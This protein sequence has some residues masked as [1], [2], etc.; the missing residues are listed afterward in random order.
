VALLA[1]WVGG[2][3]QLATKFLNQ[4]ADRKIEYLNAVDPANDLAGVPPL[5]RWYSSLRLTATKTL[6]EA[7]SKLARTMA[8]SLPRKLSANS[9]RQKR[10]SRL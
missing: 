2:D 6:V 4:A 1:L 3:R 7:E 9:K 8:E 5:A 10:K